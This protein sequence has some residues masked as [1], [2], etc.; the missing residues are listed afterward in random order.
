LIVGRQRAHFVKNHGPAS[1]NR[2][3]QEA[4]ARAPA[5]DRFIAIP[6]QHPHNVAG[7]PAY[8]YEEEIDARHPH[9]TE[10]LVCRSRQA[11]VVR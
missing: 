9:A 7:H 1:R 5:C 8:A 11:P 6:K 10:I 3:Q 4:F 2:W